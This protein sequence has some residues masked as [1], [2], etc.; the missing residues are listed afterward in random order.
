M[1][2]ISKAFSITKAPALQQIPPWQAGIVQPMALNYEAFAREGYGG[3]EIV[4]AAIQELMSSASEPQMQVRVGKEWTHEHPL[5]DLM[6]RPNPLMDRYA[7]WST[8]LMYYH[9]SG[10]AYALKVRSRFTNVVELWLLRPDRMRI[11]PDSYS[12]VRRYEY[13]I[14]AGGAGSVG[15]PIPREDIIHFKKP[16]PYNDFYG[17]SPLSIIASRIDTDNYMREFVKAYFVNAGVPGGIL[18]IKQSVSPEVKE[19]IRQGFRTNFGGPRGWHDTM[20][21]DG[22]EATFTSLTA[23][24]GTR[25]LV[26]PELD[27][28]NEARLAAPFGVPLSLIGARLGMASS[29]YGN[30]KS[31]REGFWDE[32]LSPL[33]K[34]LAGPLNLA[35]VPDFGGVDEI[36]FDLSDVRALQEDVDKVHARVRSDYTAGLE[37]FESARLSLGLP[38]KPAAGETLLIPSN[39]VPTKVSDLG[40]P[41]EL[42]APAP[43]PAPSSNGRTPA[44][45][46]NGNRP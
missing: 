10:N 18:N 14:G 46:A 28:V 6:N 21:L 17:L 27:E 34:E 23:A 33:Y 1:G 36:S 7:F 22:A 24:L 39:M 29:S 19:Q 25:G 4:F 11:V 2:L 13:Q 3:N 32:T 42:P 16:H 26:V 9:I 31:D 15:I 44:A 5:L 8:V 35:L 30:R 45:S 20:I 37:S 38:A 12:I 41:P 40:K 43:I